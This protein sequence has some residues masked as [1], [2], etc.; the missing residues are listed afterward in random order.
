[1]QNTRYE[2]I[3]AVCLCALGA[4]SGSALADDGNR[5]L[6]GDVFPHG[7]VLSSVK[8]TQLEAG[9]DLKWN[10]IPHDIPSEP[11]PGG[12]KDYHEEN[13]RLY[14]RVPVNGD[15]STVAS[16]DR[17]TQA[18]HLGIRGALAWDASGGAREH[19][20]SAAAEYGFGRYEY[21]PNGDDTTK[22]DPIEHSFDLTAEYRHV[23]FGARKDGH[24]DGRGVVPQA[25]LKYARDWRASDKVGVVM[26]GMSSVAEI[27]KD[28]VLSPPT[29]SPAVELR[30]AVPFTFGSAF[31]YAPSVAYTAQG[32]DGDWAP[33]AK[34]QRL[35]F[36]AFVYWFPVGMQGGGRIG[37][38]PFID[39]RTHGADSLHQFE[40]GGLIDLRLATNLL[41]Y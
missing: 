8:Q 28:L 39:I 37:I 41:E 36:E 15:N 2:R 19:R 29:V 40:Y 33:G 32:N 16:L 12:R 6:S 21:S 13:L 18:L 35:R 14:G 38:S 10:N 34:V 1:M 17:F 26:P 22:Q 25:R 5:P 4:S 11:P 30:I 9:L 31:G 24:R 27:T 3:A 20:I 7:Q 23:W